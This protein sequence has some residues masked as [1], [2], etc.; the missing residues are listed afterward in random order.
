MDNRTLCGKGSEMN[1]FVKLFEPLRI[2]AVEIKNRVAMAPI[3]IG[4]QPF[5]G[6]NPLI[7]LGANFGD[8]I[9]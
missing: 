6:V 1:P 7:L 3:G 2:G 8:I 4:G 5:Q 9:S